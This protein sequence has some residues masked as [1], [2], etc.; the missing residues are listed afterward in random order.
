MDHKPFK[1]HL[2]CPRLDLLLVKHTSPGLIANQGRI[3]DE[4]ESE[5]PHGHQFE[6]LLAR[7]FAC[8]RQ[9]QFIQQKLSSG[10]TCTLALRRSHEGETAN[11]LSVPP[12]RQTVEPNGRG[13]L[14]D[15]ARCW[16]CEC[17]NNQNTT[18][19]KLNLAWRKIQLASDQ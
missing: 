16:G 3:D 8:T 11:S 17:R 5:R 4:F 13:S 12:S 2:V 14:Q 18:V 1:G 9:H 10:L 19:R 15:A 7:H 6:E